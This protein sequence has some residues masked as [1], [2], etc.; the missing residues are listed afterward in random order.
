MYKTIQRICANVDAHPEVPFRAF[1][2]RVHFRVRCFPAFFRESGASMIV[3]STIVP[4]SPACLLPSILL[5]LVEEGFC[6]PWVCRSFRNLHGCGVRYLGPLGKVQPQE[7]LHG[8]AVVYGILYPFIGDGTIPAASAYAASPLSLRGPAAL[9]IR[10]KGAH[11][12]H[13]SI[14][15]GKTA[16][17]FVKKTSRLVTFR[18]LPYSKS[19]K[20]IC[21]S[22]SFTSLPYFTAISQK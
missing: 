18:L 13:H 19:V 14:F 11:Q 1:L 17:I 20:L 16:S 21:F 7:G 8:V 4:P 3:A 5:H 15:H 2:D 9:S 22:I 6:R 10:E 12:F